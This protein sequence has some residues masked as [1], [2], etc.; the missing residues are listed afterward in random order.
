[1][2]IVRRYGGRQVSTAAL[3]GARR[4]AAE[5]PESLGAG[6]ER[7]KADTARA[8]SRVAAQLTSEL[9]GVASDMARQER[10]RA[11]DVQALAWSNRFSEWEA[12]RLWDAK[13]GAMNTSGA[14]A[15]ELPEQIE[16]EF[17]ALADELGATASNDRQRLAFERLRSQKWNGINLDVRRH[18][19]KQIDKYESE[20]LDKGIAN[21]R[22]AAITH[23]LDPQR[24]QVELGEIVDTI[25]RH[26]PRLGMGPE[27]IQAAVDE[28]RSAVHAGVITRLLNT[29]HTKAAQI[30]FE[31]SREQITNPKALEAVEKALK[32][33]TLTAKAQA[34]T[35]RIRAEHKTFTEQREAAKQIEDTDLR[36]AVASR[37]EHENQI[38][39][40]V[41]REAQEASLVSA[42]NLVDQGA[43]QGQVVELTKLPGWNTYSGAARSS[44][45]AY[46]QSVI[47]GVPVQTVWRTYTRLMDMAG[48]KPEA[49]AK[50][51]LWD[52]RGQLGD[53]E[54]KSLV[55]LQLGYRPGGDRGKSDDQASRYRTTKDILRATIGINPETKPGSP[56]TVAFDRLHRILDR[57]VF[58]AEQITGKRATTEDIQGFLDDLLMTQITTRQGTG[59]NWSLFPGG[60]VRD[61]IT[62]SLSEIQ[63]GDIPSSDKKQIETTLRKNGL[64]VTSETILDLYIESKLRGMKGK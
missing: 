21:R 7:A 59:S 20:E 19:A 49:F 22:A 9:A 12:S 60:S 56:E 43:K 34:E 54:Y 30:Y 64:P 26:G 63:I 38:D 10:D 37:L 61:S 39:D 24:V 27:A 23:A 44:L 35:D 45:Q 46:Q 50:V 48:D 6:V 18:V 17:N 11:D 62:K 40:R 1:M 16:Q 29:D 33:G 3:P 8:G 4:Q 15:F 14:Q 58:D 13:T 25:R 42:F 55:N 28:E 31:E 51:N 5:T 41:E 52:Y 36:D 32:D 2:P 57:R 53:V 47:E